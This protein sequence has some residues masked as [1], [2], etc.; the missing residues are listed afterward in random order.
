MKKILLIFISYILVSCASSS[1]YSLKKHPCSI[2]SDPY[3]CY[4]VELEK[5]REVLYSLWNEKK[6]CTSL[7]KYESARCIEEIQPK[8]D[9]AEKRVRLQSN[10]ID[11]HLA[12]KEKDKLR[13]AED[14]YI[15]TKKEVARSTQNDN[16]DVLIDILSLVDD[17]LNPEPFK[18]DLP[19][20]DKP[21]VPEFS[22]PEQYSIAVP[23]SSGSY[24][25][26]T[27]PLNEFIVRDLI[28]GKAYKG[29]ANVT[30]DG[31]LFE[32]GMTGR[33]DSNGN[34]IFSSY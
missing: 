15:F 34:F 30:Q 23:L 11:S 5:R 16:S 33:I 9:L 6:K 28:T 29:K 17:A 20:F 12:V 26:E 1:T 13:L 8:I 31:I 7:S 2:Y 24:K 10:L 32:N 18:I 22:V 4:K 27:T 21:I 19:D 14:P 3:M 25:V